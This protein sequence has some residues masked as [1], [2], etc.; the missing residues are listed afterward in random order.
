MLGLGESKHEVIEVMTDLRHNNC[1]ILTIGQYLQPSLKHY[2]LV[3]YVYPEEFVE[4][5]N[6]GKRL[7]FRQV[8]AGPLVRSSFNAARTYRLAISKTAH[9]V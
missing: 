7:G 6:I 8:V 4:Y 2:K 3:K 5:A 1:D 9:H